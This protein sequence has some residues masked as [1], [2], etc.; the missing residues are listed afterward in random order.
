MDYKKIGG[1]STTREEAQS[2]SLKLPSGVLVICPHTIELLSLNS[3]NTQISDETIQSI[4][5]IAKSLVNGTDSTGWRKIPT[6]NHYVDNSVTT[7]RSGTKNYQ[8]GQS[9]NHVHHFQ[10]NSKYSS[11][12][13]QKSSFQS[14]QLSQTSQTSQTS[15]SSTKHFQRQN[16]QS[17]E[18]RPAPQKY[19]SRFQNPSKNM[20]S[21]ILN[22]IIL[23]KLNKFS[24]Q[25]Y[26]EIKEFLEQILD[27]GQTE[28][29]KDFMKL[30]FE[31]AATE[32]IFCALYARLLGEL[33]SSYPILICEME[34]LYNKFIHVFDE[35]SEE[36]TTTYS[37][38]LD[39]NNQ[40]IYRLGYSQFLT[41]LIPYSVV[42]SDFLIKVIQAILD[43]SLK[44]VGQP[45]N[46]KLVEEYT[47]CLVRILK[48]IVT[49]KHA[50][51]TNILSS[52]DI[53]RNIKL[54]SIKNSEFKSQSAKTR[55]SCLDI[56]EMLNVG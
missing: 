29:L 24:P 11:Q 34:F 18:Y 51:L 7:F 52:G 53:L 49:M 31:K 44:I 8:Q 32:S 38:L 21:Q 36:L 33:S 19:I 20:D 27:S 25:N 16:Y 43:N 39:A 54:L 10:S 2:P 13:Q 26:N 22:T 40:K 5:S 50:E 28:F 55:F 42:K 9:H 15:Q 37:E 23:G 14:P 56:I 48:S 30:V 4:N 45:N 47:D 12:S 6:K 41:E 1:T 3:R 46:I 17:N 35:I